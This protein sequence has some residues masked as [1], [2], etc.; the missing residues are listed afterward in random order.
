MAFRQKLTALIFLIPLLGA[1]TTNDLAREA[2]VIPSA[3]CFDPMAPGVLEQLAAHLDE[4]VCVRGWAWHFPNL[5]F[6]TQRMFDEVRVLSD[7]HIYVDLDRY[8]TIDMGFFPEDQIDAEHR[9]HQFVEIRGRLTTEPDDADRCNEDYCGN[10]LIVPSSIR[11]VEPDVVPRRRLEAIPDWAVRDCYDADQRE[12]WDHMVAAQP[13]SFCIYGHLNAGTFI[14]YFD[15]DERGPPYQPTGVPLRHINLDLHWS[16]AWAWGL[17]DEAQML[18]KGED[19][20]F[21]L[22]RFEKWDL[23]CRVDYCRGIT[24]RPTEM[25]RIEEPALAERAPADD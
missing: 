12:T 3:E 11:H 2:E 7:G 20:A 18:A 19:F 10:V 1:C 25:W 5:A 14:R 8:E 9:I 22:A 21:V 23:G 17:V 4:A 6:S 16:E 13:A 15:L 24:L